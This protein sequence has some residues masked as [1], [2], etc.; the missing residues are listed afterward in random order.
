MRSLTSMSVYIKHNPLVMTPN[1]TE[2][3]PVVP[4][5]HHPGPPHKTCEAPRVAKFIRNPLYTLDEFH[6]KKEKLSHMR[7]CE[8]A[9]QLCWLICQA[10]FIVQKKTTTT[11]IE[12]PMNKQYIYSTNNV[13]MPTLSVTPILSALQHTIYHP[14]PLPPPTTITELICNLLPYNSAP[15]SNQLVVQATLPDSYKNLKAVL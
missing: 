6:N 14:T 10:I 12:P 11:T 13:K 15:N 7:V 2:E 4:P 5:P 1:R 3:A 9:K 8:P